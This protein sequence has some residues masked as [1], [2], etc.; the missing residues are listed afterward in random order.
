MAVWALGDIQ[1]CYDALRGLL[2][3]INFDPRHDTLWFAGDLVNR[4]P[5]SLETLRYLHHLN[6]ITVLGN[7]DLHLLASAHIPKYRKHKDTLQQIIDAEDGFELLDWLRHQ[8]LLYH[9]EHSGYTLIHAGLPPQWDL[10]TAQVCAAEVETVLRGPDYID[11]LENM[12][13]NQPDQW[14]ESLCGQDRLRF[15]TN[16]LTRLR[17]CDA[18]GRLAL[19]H[20]GPP[21]S[22]PKHL[23]PWFE[24]PRK[25]A[26]MKILFGHWSTLGP[27]DGDG[28]HA[29][30]TGCLWGGKLTAIRLDRPQPKREEYDCPEAKSPTK[31]R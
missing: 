9:D 20:K 12:Y 7:H 21:G 10:Q 3:Q 16:C 14:S 4:G 13:G 28:I 31:I 23:K 8:P 6:A 25:S 15:I 26:D 22:Q 18:D 17:Y 5:K 1:G 11:F 19:E 24:W 30:D 2:E 29:L 27:L